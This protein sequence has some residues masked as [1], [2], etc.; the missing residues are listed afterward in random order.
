MICRQP[1]L[2]MKYPGSHLHAN[3]LKWGPRLVRSLCEQESLAPRR[4][5]SGELCGS[6]PC[7]L[8]SRIGLGISVEAWKSSAACPCRSCHCLNWRSIA[9]FGF[10]SWQ[11][12][13]DISF[14][15]DHISLNSSS[16]ELMP[17]ILPARFPASGFQDIR[18]YTSAPN[19]CRW[20]SRINWSSTHSKFPHLICV[21]EGT[22][23]CQGYNP[24]PCSACRIYPGGDLLYFD[25]M[26]DS[27]MWSPGGWCW[28]RNLFW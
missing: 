21:L 17:R 16:A 27:N 18:Q 9:A 15:S 25:Q 5:S 8:T 22:K 13:G 14:N 2:Y 3:L 4:Q 20:L 12:E 28:W 24:W 7:A 10:C 11:Q 19:S 1:R 26:D 23:F 6:H